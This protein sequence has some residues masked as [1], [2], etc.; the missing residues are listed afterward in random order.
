VFYLH[1]R[2][3]GRDPIVAGCQNPLHHQWIDF[4]PVLSIGEIL[5]AGVF[6]IPMGATYEVFQIDQDQII[7][8]KSA[9]FEAVRDIDRGDS[10]AEMSTDGDPYGH[11]KRT[12]DYIRRGKWPLLVVNPM[13]TM[14]NEVVLVSYMR[15]EAIDPFPHYNYK[16]D[17]Q[18]QKIQ[19]MASD[20]LRLRKH[21]EI[22]GYHF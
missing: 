6:G 4:T 16:Y 1:A 20:I 7:V 19:L 22:L 11:M 12:V 13:D 10:T 21:H 18:V 14:M 8:P 17:F 3:N 2:S 5:S 15:V 9:A